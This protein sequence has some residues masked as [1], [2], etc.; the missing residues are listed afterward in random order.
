MWFLPP[1]IIELAVLYYWRAGCRAF[2][3]WRDYALSL[4]FSEMSGVPFCSLNQANPE[5]VRCQPT[6]LVVLLALPGDGNCFCLFSS[7][8]LLYNICEHTTLSFFFFFYGLHIWFAFADPL[9]KVRRELCRAVSRTLRRLCCQNCNSYSLLRT[10]IA[11]I[12]CR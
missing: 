5:S 1:G 7:P 10:D 2:P 3:P 4:K 6:Q 11:V 8:G 12:C 9:V